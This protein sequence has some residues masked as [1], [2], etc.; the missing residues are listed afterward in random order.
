MSNELQVLLC[1]AFFGGF[2][3]KPPISRFRL[4]LSPTPYFSTP[5]GI[6][7]SIVANS[8]LFVQNIPIFRQSCVV[9]LK[10]RLSKISVQ[11]MI[12]GSCFIRYMM[13]Q[14]VASPLLHSF[15][16]PNP[17]GNS[18]WM[19]YVCGAAPA[20]LLLIGIETFFLFRPMIQ[21]FLKR[22]SEILIPVDLGILPVL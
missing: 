10:S 4:R 14:S 18:G 22:W 8:R 20:P 1:H 2:A 17:L 19:K 9:L 7:F 16:R 5:N 13:I 21:R 6:G 15:V 11:I 3:S 12:C